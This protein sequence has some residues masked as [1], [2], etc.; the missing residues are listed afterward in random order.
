MEQI[1]SYLKSPIKIQILLKVSK[2]GSSKAIK[3]ILKLKISS[4]AFRD[5]D[6]YFL[7][8]KVKIIPNNLKLN[9][10]PELFIV[11]NPKKPI[12]KPIKNKANHYSFT[13][14]QRK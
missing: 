4:L 9:K 6:I 12:L 14:L 13:Y 2:N 3:I 7:V 1:K 8:S 5:L 10:P 11:S